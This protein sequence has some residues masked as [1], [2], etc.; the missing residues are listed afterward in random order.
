MT[1]QEE[2]GARG[3]DGKPSASGIGDKRLSMSGCATG[4][5]KSGDGAKSRDGPKIEKGTQKSLLKVP[6][7]RGSIAGFHAGILIALSAKKEIERIGGCTTESE[8]S[9]FIHDAS[10]MTGTENDEREDEIDETAESRTEADE[11]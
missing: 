7:V 11:G 1:M 6:N 10:S 4:G 8:S 3:D 9:T 5:A 2:A